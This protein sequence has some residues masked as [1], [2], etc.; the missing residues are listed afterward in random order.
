MTCVMNYHFAKPAKGHNYCLRPR[1]VTQLQQY[2]PNG[3]L[4]EAMD[5]VYANWW[6]S[7]ISMEFRAFLAPRTPSPGFF[8]TREDMAQG[9]T[10]T[11]CGCIMGPDIP[12]D[13][14][15]PGEITLSCG[16]SSVLFSK[17]GQGLYSLVSRQDEEG[18]SWTWAQKRKG[19]EVGCPQLALVSYHG[20]KRCGDGLLTETLQELFELKDDYDGVTLGILTSRN[21]QVMRHWCRTASA[22]DMVLLSGIWVAY[23]VGW[24]SQCR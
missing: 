15:N 17:H 11:F 6:N 24:I 14:E 5:F 7:R 23:S 10:T 8:L 1:L 20:P 21:I 4:H 19:T 3:H 12:G 18:L 13:C 9:G 2:D 22:E 16:A